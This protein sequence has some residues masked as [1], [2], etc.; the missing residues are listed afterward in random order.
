MIY[1]KSEIIARSDVM[2]VQEQSIKRYFHKGKLVTIVYTEYGYSFKIDDKC[3]KKEYYSPPFET[4]EE[5]E[6]K[7]YKVAKGI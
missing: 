4:L 1:L 2:T 5:C 6:A 3:N 7:S